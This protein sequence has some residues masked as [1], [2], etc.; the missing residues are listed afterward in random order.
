M[1]VRRPPRVRARGRPGAHARAA[2]HAR[3][4]AG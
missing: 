3:R 2:R 4:R 1:N